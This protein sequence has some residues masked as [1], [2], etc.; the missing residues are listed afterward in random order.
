[1]PTDVVLALPFTLLREVRLDVELPAVK[2]KA[3]AE[4]GYGTNAK[5]MVGF[6][7][8]VWRDRPGRSN[9]SVATDLPFQST[10]E[11]SRAAGRTLGRAR[12]TSPA[13]STASPWAGDGRA[14]RRTASRASSS[15]SSPAWP[16]R[17]RARRRCASTGRPTRGRWAATPAIAPGSGRA[18]AG[19]EGEAVGGLHFAGEH[20]SLEAQGFMEGGCETGE[21]AARPSSRRWAGPA[22]RCARPSQPHPSF[23]RPRERRH[24]LSLDDG[25]PAPEQRESHGT[26]GRAAADALRPRLRL[27]PEHVAVRGARASRTTYRVVLF[28]HVGAGG[29]DPSAFDPR[30]VRLPA[31]LRGRRARDL[32]RARTST[33]CVFVGHSVS[34]M[35]GVLAGA[36]RSPSASGGWCWSGPSPRYIDERRLRGRLRAARTSTGC[37]SPSTATTSAGRR[38][39]PRVIMGNPDRP[40]AGRRAHQQLLPDRSRRSRGT[41][42]A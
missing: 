14:S 13:A 40:G 12:R 21:A 36:S 28:D 31:R 23:V 29:S 1:M 42:P 34:A 10:W 18:I 17:A 4:L 30:A 6:S 26:G 32:P 38:P 39:W 2:R 24:R 35:I 8:R 25:C 9:G 3:I 16:R 11:T 41:S 37:S 20:C 33:T 22:R 27:R 15:A 19:A 7:E 5:L